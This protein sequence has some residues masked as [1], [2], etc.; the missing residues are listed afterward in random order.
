[1]NTRVLDEPLPEFVTDY[2]DNKV[3]PVIVT[4]NQIEFQVKDANDMKK[5]K[6]LFETLKTQAKAHLEAQSVVRSQLATVEDDAVAERAYD[7]LAKKETTL[8]ELLKRVVPL[9]KGGRRLKTRK[10]RRVKKGTRRG[11]R[12]HF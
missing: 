10:G 9:L 2:L 5:A 6:E 12:G 8:Q 3:D 4:L 7:A 11:R 1:M